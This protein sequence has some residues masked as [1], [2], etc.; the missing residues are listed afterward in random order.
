[1][2]TDEPW[3]DPQWDKAGR[4]HDWR[5]HISEEIE[6][7]WDTFTDAQKAALYRQAQE[8]ASAEEWE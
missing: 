7:M 6:A 5:N 1:M 8:L 4:V 3:R 2:N